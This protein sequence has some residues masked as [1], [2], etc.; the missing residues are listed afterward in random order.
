MIGSI[1]EATVVATGVDPA[2]PLLLAELNVTEVNKSNA[3][4]ITDYVWE[5]ICKEYGNQ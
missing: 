1:Y 2:K 4:Q 3:E 5:L